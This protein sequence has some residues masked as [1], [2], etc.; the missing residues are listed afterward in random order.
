[1]AW[2][3]CGSLKNSREQSRPRSGAT[4]TRAATIARAPANARA[5]PLDGS[6]CFGCLAGARRKAPVVAK[7]L[8]APEAPLAGLPRELHFRPHPN[9]PSPSP[10]CGWNKS[11]QLASQ[12]LAYNGALLL[13]LLSCSTCRSCCASL[14]TFSIVL[15]YCS[16][17]RW[18]R[19]LARPELETASYLLLVRPPPP[20][21]SRADKFRGD[22]PAKLLLSPV[23]LSSAHFTSVSSSSSSPAV[24]YWPLSPAANKCHRRRPAQF[25]PIWA[26]PR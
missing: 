10:L 6:I 26:P 3:T 25:R 8:G 7:L 2:P 24:I 15:E 23:Q 22:N 18:I 20:P 21:S 1:M 5:A 4:T 13:L 16:S 11:A 19:R 17:V 14:P 9:P 12:R